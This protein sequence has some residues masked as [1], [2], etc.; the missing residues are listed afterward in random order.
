VLVADD[1]PVSRQVTRLQIMKLG[2]PV[3]VVASGADAVKAAA[4]GTYH[5]LFLDC[6]MPDVDG[7][8]AAAAI[9]RQEAPDHRA[10]IVALTADV[11]PIQ[12]ERCRA[13][14]MDEFLEKPLRIQTLAELLNRHLRSHPG[15]RRSTRAGERDDVS[16]LAHCAHLLEADIGPEMTHELVRE[17]LTGAD[18]AIERL[19]HPEHCDA[20]TVQRT[21]HRLLGGAR[22]LGLARFERAWAALSDR[23][24]GDPSVPPGM[25]DELRA[26]STELTAWLDSHPRKQHV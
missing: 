13:A 20:G 18:L 8:T 14:G 22:V 23:S 2:Y 10:L 15:S 3:D 21:A 17:Y 5:L 26:A 12:R 25:L 7:L 16:P 9:R 11:S 24:A 4:T 19:A 1:D 6:Q